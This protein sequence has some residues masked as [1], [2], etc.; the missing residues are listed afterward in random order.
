MSTENRD[1]KLCTKATKSRVF[2]FGRLRQ[3][4]E[5]RK[6][7]SFFYELTI[8]MDSDWF[9][10]FSRRDPL[11]AHCN[12]LLCSR[13]VSLTVLWS[14]WLF[15]R[16]LKLG[17]RERTSK[18]ETFSNNCACD[19]NHLKKAFHDWSCRV[20][21]SSIQHIPTPVISLPC[22]STKIKTPFQFSFIKYIISICLWQYVYWTFDA[23]L[24]SFS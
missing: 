2:F 21:A 14:G 4:K 1:G 20:Y 10:L 22:G 13:R 19:N 24:I 3:I 23:K 17:H 16:F 6:R 11:L 8:I 7:G 5:S 9:V 18:T 15:S 12:L